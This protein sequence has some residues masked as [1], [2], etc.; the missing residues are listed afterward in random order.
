MARPIPFDLPPRDPQR[1]L[2]VRLEQVPLEH[3]EAVLA[4][5]QVLQALHDRGVLELLRGMLGGSEKILEQVV[6]VTKGPEGIRA[7]RNL[8]LLA[9]ALG[10][11]EPAVLG[12]LTRAVPEALAVN[13]GQ[14]SRPPGFF[15]L[16]GLLWNKDFRRGL[17]VFT[18]LMARFGRNLSE[19]DSSAHLHGGEIQKRGN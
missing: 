18:D 10:E 12:D 7:T 13:N 17:S 14:R 3:G 6:D 1:E 19:R 16:V 4:A 8:V 5:Y 15:K 2:S 9:K 11:I